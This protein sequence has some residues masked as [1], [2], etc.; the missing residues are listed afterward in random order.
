MNVRTINPPHKVSKSNEAINIAK[1]AH[2][3]KRHASVSVSFEP[4]VGR[5][6]HEV[7]FFMRSLY[8]QV[9][10]QIMKLLQGMAGRLDLTL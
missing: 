8:Q 2:T 9:A 4:T 10:P 3:R 7:T 1:P 6:N 5:K